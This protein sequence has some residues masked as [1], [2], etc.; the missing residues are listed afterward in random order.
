MPATTAAF[1]TALTPLALVAALALAAAVPAQAQQPLSQPSV[2]AL[3][4]ALKGGGK[5][6][7]PTARA[8][9]RTELPEAGTSLCA[10]EG[11]GAAAPASPAA[12]ASGSAPFDVATVAGKQPGGTRARNL[13]VVPYAGDTTPG[14][15]LDVRFATASDKLTKAD[16]TLLDTLAKALKTPDLAKDRFA[17]AGHTDATGDD[18]INQ[19]L[20]CARALAVK[21]YLSGKG[22][23]LARLS[24]YGFGSGRPLEAG[25][26]DSPANRRVEIRKAPE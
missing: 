20:S 13:E 7:G 5:G 8:F 15:N 17:V 11:G 14:V 26:T 16:Q 10:G 22:V 3:V 24:A 23:A 6:S 19:E 21:R 1:R 9:K 25:Q 4:K 18:R 2:E 12:P